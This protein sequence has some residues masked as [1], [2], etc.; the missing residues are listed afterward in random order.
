VSKQTDTSHGPRESNPDHAASGEHAVDDSFG[1]LDE[2]LDGLLDDGDAARADQADQIDQALSDVGEQAHALSDEA[3][4]AMLAATR[5]AVHSAADHS[6]DSQGEP[7]EQVNSSAATADEAVDGSFD[8]PQDILGHDL[9]DEIQDLL[10]QD[11]ARETLAD[12]GRDAAV[13]TPD[14]EDAQGN[15]DGELVGDL[16]SPDDLLD[17]DPQSAADSVADPPAGQTDAAVERP[18]NEPD[19]AVTETAA[20]DEGVNADET[21]DEVVRQIDDLIASEADDAVAGDFD[22]P[23]AVFEQEGE[24]V[25]DAA[26]RPDP[27]V[28]TEPEPATDAN[29]APATAAGRDVDD[30]PSGNFESIDEL[31]AGDEDGEHRDGASAGDV[32]DE[33]DAQPELQPAA[34]SPEPHDDD[35]VDDTTSSATDPPRWQRIVA[36]LQRELAPSRLRARWQHAEPRLIALCEKLNRP[37]QRFRPE[38]RDAVGYVGLVTVFVASTVLLGKVV[39]IL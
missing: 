26:Q 13:Q 11:K 1:K 5:D 18:T 32:A 20:D 39:G 7:A 19:D 6:E 14:S 33:L 4:D 34:A 3:E 21:D 8:S 22:T 9:A 37:L 28:S 35:A 10:E 29:P 25:T 12:A 36:A 2:Q 16:Q 24:R 27:P 30:V 38:V 17:N 23:E 31:L 15:D